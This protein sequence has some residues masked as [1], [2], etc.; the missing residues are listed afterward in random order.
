[1]DAD[2]FD[3]ETLRACNPACNVYLNESDLVGEASMAACSS[4]AEP[5]IA[6]FG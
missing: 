4:G 1:M 5:A 3:I 6:A 2:P